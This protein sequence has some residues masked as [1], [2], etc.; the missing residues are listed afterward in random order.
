LNEYTEDYD[1]VVAT[2]QKKYDVL[3]KMTQS[4]M[5]IDMMNIM[6]DIR[7]KQMD[8]LEQAINMWKSRNERKD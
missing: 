3:W 1:V 7:L 8:E 4:N 5:D 2:L 6:D